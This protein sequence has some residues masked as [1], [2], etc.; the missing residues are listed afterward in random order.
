MRTTISTKGQIVLPAELR[1]AARHLEGA[2]ESVAKDLTNTEMAEATAA[3]AAGEVLT[4]GV[5]S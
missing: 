1:E 4:V 2:P 5:H 3:L